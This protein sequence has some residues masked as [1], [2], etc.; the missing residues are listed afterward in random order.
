M[1]SSALRMSGS[2]AASWLRRAI[3]NAY[4]RKTPYSQAPPWRMVWVW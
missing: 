1:T 2:A 4:W 3:H